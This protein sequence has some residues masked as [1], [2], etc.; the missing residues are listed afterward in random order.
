[1]E[2]KTKQFSTAQELADFVN[3]G[4]KL[5]PTSWT[6]ESIILGGSNALILFYWD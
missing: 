1:M 3:A 4:R 6:V 5:N 2:L